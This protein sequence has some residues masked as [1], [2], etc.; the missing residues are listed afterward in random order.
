MPLALQSLNSGAARHKLEQ[1]RAF[2]QQWQPN[3]KS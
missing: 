2:T 3:T 1:L